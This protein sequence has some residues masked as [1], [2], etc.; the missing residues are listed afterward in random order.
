MSKSFSKSKTSTQSIKEIV[1]SIVRI[2]VH[3]FRE[4][5][6]DIAMFTPNKQWT[7]NYRIHRTYFQEAEKYFI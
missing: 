5:E 1:L 3:V 6:Q 2:Y 7:T 4:N